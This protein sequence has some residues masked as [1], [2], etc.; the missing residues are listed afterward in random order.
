MRSALI[1]SLV[2]IQ[3]TAQVCA[4]ELT[5]GDNEA[6]SIFICDSTCQPNNDHNYS[7]GEGGKDWGGQAM[8]IG[9]Q[10]TL[11]GLCSGPCAIVVEDGTLATLE[12]IGFSEQ[13]SGADHA[14]IH[15]NS[16]KRRDN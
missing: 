10:E 2:L 1:A 3:M 6:H 7:R 5:N 14:V 16:V 8:T 12:D 11:S 13:F 4:V 15:G 9:G